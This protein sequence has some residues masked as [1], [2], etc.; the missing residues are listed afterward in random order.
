MNTEDSPMKT[1]TTKIDALMKANLALHVARS[2]P[3]AAGSNRGQFMARPEADV[4]RCQAELTATLN[5][6]FCPAA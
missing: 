3:G 5:T 6:I 1:L 2:F 4:A